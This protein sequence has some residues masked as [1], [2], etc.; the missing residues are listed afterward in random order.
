MFKQAL[1]FDHEVKPTRSKSI[2]PRLI[3][4]LAACI[5]L[6]PLAAEGAAMC[7]AQWS[8]ILGKTT[9]VRTP[10]VDTMGSGLQRVRELLAVS[11]WAPFERAIHDPTVALPIA[12]LFLVVAMAILRR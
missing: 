3:S 9:E 10:I 12:S 11:R 7:Y 2:V 1:L 6:V 4:V 8:G 5:F